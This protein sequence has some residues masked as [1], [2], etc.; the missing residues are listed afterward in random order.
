MT[1]FSP[2]TVGRVA[3]RRSTDLPFTFTEMR[4]S[5]GTRR[6]AMLIS[7]MTFRREITPAWICFGA[8]MTSWSTP[9]TRYRMRRS[10]SVGS[11]WM[12][13]ARSVTAWLI[14]RFTNLTIGASSMSSS[15]RVE[16]VEL[17]ELGGGLLRHRVHLAVE[18]VDPFDER[19][20]PGWAAR[21]R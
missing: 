15:M 21:R 1:T 9:S 6:S 12:S 11:T 19:R 10:C 7:A 5:W 18:A 17:A 8:C 16:S 20:A 2:Y 14:V 13:D 4:P 3:T